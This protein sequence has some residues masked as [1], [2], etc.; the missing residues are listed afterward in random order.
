VTLALAL[1]A[2]AVVIVAPAARATSWPPFLPPTRSFSP[3]MV[4]AVERNWANVS[5]SRHVRG[6]PARAPLDVYLGLV[7]T[8]E[9]ITAAA[10]H[11]GLARDV[12]LTGSVLTILTLDPAAEG[13]GQEF[14][15]HVQ[16]DNRFAAYLAWLLQPLFRGSMDAKLRQV[17]TVSAG[18][19][20]W[21]SQKPAEFCT[22]LQRQPVAP[23]RLARLHAAT[24]ACPR[25]APRGPQARPATR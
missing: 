2:G 9:V 11:L 23:D 22:W 1:V 12:V 15:V 16:I 21:A 6:Q 25:A 17:L 5:F 7:E 3:D 19:S 24:A 18:V 10:R 14:T 20:E 13:I 8:P 4:A